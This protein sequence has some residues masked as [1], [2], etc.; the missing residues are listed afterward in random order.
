MAAA[1]VS[2]ASGMVCCA[3]MA[4][5]GAPNMNGEYFVQNGNSTDSQRQ[6]TLPAGSFSTNF[7]TY[8]E[9]GFKGNA[10]KFVEAYSEQIETTYSQVWWTMGPIYK[11]PKPFVEEYSSKVMAIVGY[12]FDQVMQ[13]LD[14][15][16]TPVPVTWSYNHHYSARV[17]GKQAEMYRQPVAAEDR[18]SF[19]HVGHLSG[20]FRG[21]PA[22]VWL[23][24]SA[25]T[26][27]TPN[28]TIPAIVDFG[29]TQPSPRVFTAFVAKR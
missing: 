13:S 8:P 12:E 16:E 27:P 11:F 24:K 23:A 26:D 22:S 29:K 1:L 20:A 18:D 10:V 5:A 9:L 3:T 25:K 15:T 2:F 17:V 6:P 7:S 21:E 19:D 4:A 14:G 28:S